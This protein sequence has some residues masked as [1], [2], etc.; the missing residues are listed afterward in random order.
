[1]RGCL[2]EYGAELA[3]APEKASALDLLEKARDLRRGAVQGLQAGLRPG[4][5]RQTEG[6]EPFTLRKTVQR[7]RE[8]ERVAETS[9]QIEVTVREQGRLQ[10]RLSQA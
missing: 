7:R 1:V 5:Q 3:R 2:G 6:M 10:Q 9:K 4:E 8:A